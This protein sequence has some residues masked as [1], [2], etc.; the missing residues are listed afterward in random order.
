MVDR[1][2]QI[3]ARMKA[4]DAELLEE[5]LKTLGAKLDKDENNTPEELSF[6]IRRHQVSIDG[7]PMTISTE[8]DKRNGSDE[9]VMVLSRAGVQRLI[10]WHKGRVLC[11]LGCVHCRTWFDKWKKQLR[12]SCRVMAGPPRPGEEKRECKHFKKKEP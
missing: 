4:T 9:A 11:L 10:E 8:Y 3:L 1:A 5:L 7:R 6:Y 12:I 2:A